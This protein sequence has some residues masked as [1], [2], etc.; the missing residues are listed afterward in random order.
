M[1]SSFC[2]KSYVSVGS[3]LSCEMDCAELN[4]TPNL[5]VE[6]LADALRRTQNQMARFLSAAG[7]SFSEQILIIDRKV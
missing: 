6:P 1:P 7:S 5:S 2:L 3:V 4:P